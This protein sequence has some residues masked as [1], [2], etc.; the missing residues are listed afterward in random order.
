MP[1][2]NLVSQELWDSFLKI[3]QKAKAVNSTQAIKCLITELHKLRTQG[4][5]PTEVVNQSIRS[6][7]KDVYPLKNRLP[8]AEMTQGR[9]EFNRQQT[10]IA[11]PQLLK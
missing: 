9:D 11:R 10:E 1:D 2:Q 8:T 5:D 7:W 3:R 4:H 6:T